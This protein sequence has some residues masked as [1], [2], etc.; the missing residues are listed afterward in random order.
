MQ[1]FIPETWMWF[2]ICLG[3]FFT[4]FILKGQ[5]SKYFFTQGAVREKFS[6][7][8]IEFSPSPTHLA[9]LLSG[10]D[11]LPDNE[12]ANVKR[13]LKVN[14]FLDFLFM[15]SIYPAIFLL[16]MHTSHKMEHIGK[17][18]FAVIAWIQLVP[19]LLDISENIYI[20][21]KIQHPVASSDRIHWYFQRLEIVKWLIPCIGLVCALFGLLYF[22]IEGQYSEHFLK[23]LGIFTLEILLYIGINWLVNKFTKSPIP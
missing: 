12:G 8:D 6:I 5:Q 2:S 13:S 18:L 19:W 10:I 15:V 14:L 3:L 16:C 7:I 23:Y 9:G 1:V 17:G 22:W 20:L 11:E 4:C 21:D